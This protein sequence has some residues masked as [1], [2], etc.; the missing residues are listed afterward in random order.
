MLASS[1]QNTGKHTK[2]EEILLQSLL[3]ALLVPSVSQTLRKFFMGLFIG[4]CSD[5]FFH[6]GPMLENF[7]DDSNGVIQELFQQRSLR[8]LIKVFSALIRLLRVI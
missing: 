2:I 4:S 8:G 1:P 7:L 6:Q 3:W 5:C